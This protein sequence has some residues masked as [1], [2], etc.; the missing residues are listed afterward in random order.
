VGH[1]VRL[2]AIPVMMDTGLVAKETVSLAQSDAAHVD[3]ESVKAAD[4]AITFQ[5]LSA[6][7]VLKVAPHV[8]LPL[9][10]TPAR[11]AIFIQ[12]TVSVLLV[13]HAVVAALMEAVQT[14]F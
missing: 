12:I 2:S 8:H 13:P 9:I 7:L 14:V 1:A 10:V 3:Q 11:L 6:L 5:A 4:Q